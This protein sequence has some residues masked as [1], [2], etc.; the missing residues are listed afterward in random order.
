LELKTSDEA[1]AR[2]SPSHNEIIAKSVEIESML[3]HRLINYSRDSEAATRFAGKFPM[4]VTHEP[5][6]LIFLPP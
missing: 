2:I 6:Q 4:N 5:A 1:A 3:W